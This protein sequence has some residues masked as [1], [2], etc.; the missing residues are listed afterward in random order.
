MSE[1]IYAAKRVRVGKT[2]R[3]RASG[4]WG[5]RFTNRAARVSWQKERD[6]TNATFPRD[7]CNGKKNRYLKD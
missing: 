4:A 5:N 7:S 3:D 2:A 6:S 1:D